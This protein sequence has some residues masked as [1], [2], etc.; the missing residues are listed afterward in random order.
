M[1]K[2]GYVWVLFLF[3]GCN[4][5]PDT[6]G[7]SIPEEK[8]NIL[9]AEVNGKQL[10]V[11]DIEMVSSSKNAEDSLQS[12]KVA[13]NRWVKDQ[14][15]LHEATENIPE[16]LDIN[17]LVREYRESLI[18]HHFEEKLIAT[19]LDTI[20]TEFDLQEHFEKN[21]SEYS[22]E[23]SIIRCLYI[24]VRKPVRSIKRIQEWLDEPTTKNMQYMRKYCMDYA[25][26][27]LINP[28]KWYKWEDV[29]KSFPEEF[30]ERDLKAGVQRTFAD[31]TYQHY[32]HILEFVPKK[33]NAPLSYFEEQA[34]K[35]IIRERKTRLLDDL[36]NRLY[37]ER[38]GGSNVK[39]YIE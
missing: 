7:N 33:R 1:M 27:C 25:E 22:L 13:V 21:K 37:E 39:I 23:K 18:K 35:R 9:L 17:K 10:Y 12:L 15:L 34:S 24:K 20:V 3:F 19:Q 36:R 6:D 14:L 38:K 32:I 28:D 16:D 29:K 8:D 30:K 5:Q 26:F 31:F 2:W 11:S 4:Q